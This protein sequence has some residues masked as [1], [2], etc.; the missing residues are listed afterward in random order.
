LIKFDN[1]MA[2]QMEA[3]LDI[4]L[5]PSLYEPCGLNQMYSL[6]YGT[7]P[8]VRATGGLADTVTDAD[9]EEDGVGFSFTAYD[10]DA[11]M[12]ALE[13]A[14][15]AYRDPERWREIVKRGMTKDLSWGVSASKYMD[16]YREALLQKTRV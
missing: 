3:G 13:R 14:L 16:L 2:H 5:M 15:S 11:M 12:E 4:F 1:A 9:V 6:R 10:E 8:V 7:V